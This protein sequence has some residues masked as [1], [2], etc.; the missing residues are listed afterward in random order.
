MWRNSTRKHSEQTILGRGL[1][2]PPFLIFLLWN[3][4]HPQ[5]Y[6]SSNYQLR[7]ISLKIRLAKKKRTRGE[8]AQGCEEKLRISSCPEKMAPK[9]YMSKHWKITAAIK[10]ITFCLPKYCWRCVIQLLKD[11]NSFYIKANKI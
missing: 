3:F 6:D 8:A 5:L 4:V 1:R 7:K 10:R 2:S 9:F 11:W